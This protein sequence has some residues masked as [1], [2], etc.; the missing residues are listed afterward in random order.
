MSIKVGVLGLTS[1]SNI[2]DYL[3]AEAT[4]YLLKQYS[5][6]LIIVSVDLDPRGTNT[7]PGLKALNLKI[8]NGMRV[9]QPAVFAIIRSKSFQYLY[10]YLYWHIKLNWHY[11]KSLNGLDAIVFSGGGFIK[12]KTQGLNYLD[13]QILKIAKRRNIPVMMSAVGIEGYDAR[14]IRCQNLKKALNFPVVKVITT[15]DDYQTLRT[16]YLERKDIVSS[17]VADPVLWLKEMLSGTKSVSLKLIGI[18]LINPHNFRDYGGE[19]SYEK[20]LNFYKNLI[21]E[22]QLKGQLFKLFSN[23]MSQDMQFGQRLVTD[24]NLPPATLLP[25]P[26]TSKELISDILGFDIILAARMHAGI[27]STALEVSTLGLIWSEKIDL[28]TKIVGIRDNY[29]SEQELDPAL[30]ANRLAS[31]SVTAP[32]YKQVNELKQKTTQYLYEFLDSIGGKVAN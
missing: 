10:Q 9:L 23:G 31:R 15:R 19:L 7:H 3:L 12:F 14:D 8:Y 18:N 29:F 2:G 22:L 32:N 6:T 20:V 26:T 4:K 28:F 17:Q 5:E 30:I 11:K 13:E 24:L 27:V 21:T 16:S 25:A 1:N